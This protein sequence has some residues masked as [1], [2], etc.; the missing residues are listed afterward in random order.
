MIKARLFTA[1]LHQSGGRAAM[2]EILSSGRPAKTR[3]WTRSG[4]EY[5]CGLIARND[6]TVWLSPDIAWYFRDGSGK[7]GRPQLF[8][9]A[10]IQCVLALEVLYRLPTR[11]GLGPD[12]S[13]IRWASLA[14]QPPHYTTISRRRKGTAVIPWASRRVTASGP[15]QH[16]A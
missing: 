13:R 3:Y 7:R 5:D 11:A 16:R 1:P 12:Q 15:R 6:L 9:D 8:S 4:G 14:W 2:D 10:A